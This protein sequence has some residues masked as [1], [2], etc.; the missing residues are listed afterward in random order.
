MGVFCAL[1]SVLGYFP[2]RAR[3]GSGLAEIMV[4]NGPVVFAVW[5]RRGSRVLVSPG[6]HHRHHH[7]SAWTLV[8]VDL[9]HM[10]GLLLHLGSPSGGWGLAHSQ[11]PH[12]NYLDL[13]S[14]VP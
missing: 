1:C 6:S 12:H 3:L 7:Q 10:A 11:S 8:V 2:A 5:L 4:R 13:L 9:E 14:A